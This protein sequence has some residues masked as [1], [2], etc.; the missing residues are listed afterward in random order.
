VLPVR[1]KPFPLIFAAL[2]V[3]GLATAALPFPAGGSG[4]GAASSGQNV[5]GGPTFEEATP[6]VPRGLY[7]SNLPS[8]SHYYKFHVEA[9]EPINIELRPFCNSGNNCPLFQSGSL[10]APDNQKRLSF[11]LLSPQGILLDTPNTNQGDSRL[12]VFAAPGTGEYRFLVTQEIGGFRGAYSFCFLVPPPEAHP[13]PDYGIRSQG[14]LYGGPLSGAERT[15][16]L[17]IPPTHGDLGNPFGPSAT[18]Y[19]DAATSGIHEWVRV[20]HEFADDYPQYH[21]LKRIEVQVFLF[22]G[23]QLFADYDIII[24]FVETGGTQFRGAATSCANPP[25]CIVLSLYSTA[26]RSGQVLPDYPEVDDLEGVVKH[27]FAHVW[28]LGHTL[29]WTPGHG[30]DLMNSPATFVYGDGDPVGDGGER[31][32]KQCISTLNL[33]GMALLFRHLDGQPRFNGESFSLPSSMPYS[34]YC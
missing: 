17:L 14:V 23:L 8:G 3:I 11:R 29:T 22:D 34:V 7:H 13:C 1:Q 15:R 19:L 16:V 12:L 31:S 30:P 6:L 21:Y 24:S 33:Y 18:D 28:G 32:G 4:P 10:P 20:L 25:R 9:G 5:V 27:E 2:V 26:P